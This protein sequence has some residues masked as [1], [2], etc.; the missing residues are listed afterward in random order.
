VENDDIIVE[1]LSSILGS[2]SS[3]CCPVVHFAHACWCICRARFRSITQSRALSQ[4]RKEILLLTCVSLR[5]LVDREVSRVSGRVWLELGLGACFD[6]STGHLSCS[7]GVARRCFCGLCLRLVSAAG[8]CS[9]GYG[10]CCWAPRLDALDWPS[11]SQ[12]K[13]ARGSQ[14]VRFASNG[15]RQ[16][17]LCRTDV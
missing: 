14:K 4:G 5:V 17:D 3:Q 11:I 9:C 12:S 1:F 6:E 2:Y 16:M 15:T 13:S 8:V 10:S 7:G